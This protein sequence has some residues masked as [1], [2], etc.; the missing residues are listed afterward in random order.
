M[1]LNILRPG[2]LC[3]KAFHAEVQE[4]TKANKMFDCTHGTCKTSHWDA[5]SKGCSKGC[6]IIATSEA[7]ICPEPQREI[8]DILGYPVR[9]KNYFKKQH[10]SLCKHHWKKSLY[11]MNS[12]KL[13]QPAT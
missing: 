10:A 9:K 1:P 13:V 5:M 8:R 7:G 3:Q 12:P 11:K 6:L 4:D 2:A